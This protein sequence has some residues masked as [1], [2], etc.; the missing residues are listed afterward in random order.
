[1]NPNLRIVAGSSSTFVSDNIEP[2]PLLLERASF[3]RRADPYTM[4]VDEP[5][6]RPGDQFRFIDE[7]PLLS[8]EM[9]LPYSYLTEG[10]VSY[11]TDQA[12][13]DTLTAEASALTPAEQ[14][15]PRGKELKAQLTFFRKGQ[16]QL[17]N[18]EKPGKSCSTT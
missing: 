2:Y 18:N 11:S 10:G 14:A 1:M 15:S 7:T 3:R 13:I 17:N 16:D 5:N 9:K 12:E 6:A 4:N 8:R